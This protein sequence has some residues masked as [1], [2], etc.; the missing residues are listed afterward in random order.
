M[1][2]GV[3][4]HTH[5]KKP[6]DFEVVYPIVIEIFTSWPKWQ[7]HV[8]ISKVYYADQAESTVNFAIIASKIS[9]TLTQEAEKN[10]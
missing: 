4:P 3:H 9:A 6:F 2:G 7:T 1:R 8:N 10:D 5:W